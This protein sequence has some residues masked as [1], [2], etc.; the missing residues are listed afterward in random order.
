MEGGEAL[1]DSRVIV[2]YLD[3]LSPVGK[4]IPA[5]GRERAEVTRRLARAELE[6]LAQQIAGQTESTADPGA[7]EDWLRVQ[8]LSKSFGGV[9]AVS[10]VSFELAPGECLTVV[11]HGG[12]G[13]REVDAFILLGS[14]PDGD[15]LAQDGS[16]GPVAVVGGQAGCG[17]LQDQVFAQPL[18]VQVGL[19]GLDQQLGHVLAELVAGAEVVPRQRQA[20]ACVA[21]HRFEGRRDVDLGFVGHGVGPWALW[22][23][24]G[25]IVRACRRPAGL[26]QNQPGPPPPVAA[27][28]PARNP[29]CRPPTS[30]PG[31]RPTGQ[32]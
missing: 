21:V 2:E 27:P 3:T 7:T 23:C 17:A 10:D 24:N 8:A 9:R 22:R 20:A 18:V 11:A 5:V 30:A 31:S 16:G 14:A 12:L 15:I 6:T 29:R 25:H 1:F 26:L 13:V 28:T 19:A 32:P 4:L